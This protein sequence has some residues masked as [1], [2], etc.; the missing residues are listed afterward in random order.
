MEFL[1]LYDLS[2]NDIK[3]LINR[4]DESLISSILYKK[5]EVI[6]ILDYFKSKNL[7]LKTVLLNRLDIFLMD[8]QDIKNKL[9]KYNE[10]EIIKHLKDDISLI[11][12]LG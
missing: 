10:E 12:N 5:E 1:K 7:D 9:D 2:D 3:K 11:D 6:L 4:Y 8:F